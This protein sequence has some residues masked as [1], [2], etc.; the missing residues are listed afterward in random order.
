MKDAFA[1]VLYNL[2]EL[3]K[4]L[5][6]SAVV[7]LSFF[8]LETELK[9]VYISNVSIIFTVSNVWATGAQAGVVKKE[10]RTLDRA[11]D[12]NPLINKFLFVYFLLY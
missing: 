11:K 8:S 5:C 7:I 1:H 3:A 9:G 2:I 12:Y 4:N 6:V 10:R